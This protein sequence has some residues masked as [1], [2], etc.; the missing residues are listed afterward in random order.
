MNAPVREIE[1][2]AVVL[3]P[4]RSLPSDLTI[5]TGG[6]APPGLLAA[7]GLAP[8]GAWAPVKET[9]RSETHR[10]IFIAGDAAAL[11]E[12]LPKQAYHALDM[13]VC[14]ARNAERMLAGK[15]L[16]AFRPSGKP[17]LISFGD[18]TC[19]LVVGRRAFAGPSLGAAKEAV[20]ELVMAQLDAQPL[21]TRLP[22]V[23]ERA[24]QATR[25]LLWP[26]ISSLGALRRQASLTLL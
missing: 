18:L 6:P 8:A 24:D 15:R 16:A 21:W 7:C 1:P 17:T 5:W 12:R 2:E 14:A 4:D 13:G 26:S 11:A 10:E 3:G 20:F 9:L 25:T 19:F 22:R 23:V